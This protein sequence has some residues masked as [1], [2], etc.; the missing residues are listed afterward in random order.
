MK[1]IQLHDDNIYQALSIDELKQVKGG[2]ESGYWRCNMG[3]CSVKQ[4]LQTITGKCQ[5]TMVHSQAAF[6]CTCQKNGEDI[7]VLGQA[8]SCWEYVEQ[9]GYSGS[10]D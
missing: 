2:G 10:G 4:G 1:K 5:L 9:S 3:T 7:L 6:K 8:V